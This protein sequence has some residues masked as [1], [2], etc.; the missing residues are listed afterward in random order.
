MFRSDDC[1]RTKFVND[2]EPVKSSKLFYNSKLFSDKI[3]SALKFVFTMK[4]NFNILICYFK[5]N[6]LTVKC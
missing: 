2:K 5:P 4:F 6:Y 3:N 1:V